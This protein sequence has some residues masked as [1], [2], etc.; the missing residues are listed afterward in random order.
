MRDVFAAE[1]PLDEVLTRIARTALDATADTDALS[2][3]VL[4]GGDGGSNAPR[5]V[6]YTDAHCCDWTT[7]STVP[8]ADVWGTCP[9]SS[10]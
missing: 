3:T 4:A 6:A 8:G 7:N 10:H 5:T 2:I 1:E 9:Q